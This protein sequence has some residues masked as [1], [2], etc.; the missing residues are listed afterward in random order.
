MK[1]INRLIL[2]LALACLAIV[3]LPAVTYITTTT[4]SAAVTSLTTNR[5]LLTSTAGITA[6]Y[7]GGSV[8]GCGL[9]VDREY[10]TVTSVPVSGTVQ[11]TRAAGSGTTSSTHL[12]GRVVMIA[13]QSAFSSSDYDGTTGRTPGGPC[14]TSDYPILPVVNITNGNVWLCRPG[15]A[16]VNGSTTASSTWVATNTSP[17]TYN[18]LL[19]VLP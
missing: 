1:T 6:A 14:T 15:V 8:S 19:T 16:S 17:V 12:S 4:L 5:I 18:S 13:P 11:V 3:P 2:A 9:F 7:C 10:M